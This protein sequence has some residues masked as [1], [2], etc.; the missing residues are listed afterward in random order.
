MS[1]SEALD[2]YFFKSYLIS[3]NGFPYFYS[4]KNISQNMISQLNNQNGTR[5]IAG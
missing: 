3:L 2:I 5:N 1:T 4:E